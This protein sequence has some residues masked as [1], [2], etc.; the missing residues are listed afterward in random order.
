MKK[1][2]II[3]TLVLF[4]ASTQAH[5]SIVVA[6][7]K[8]VVAL[9][10]TVSS[11][12][13][14]TATTTNVVTITGSAFTGATAVSFGGTAAASFTVV[15][16]TTITAIVAA[17]ST[18]NVSVTTPD[19]I[20]S[21][22]GF[23][24]CVSN[25][26]YADADGD[27]FGNPAISYV[28]CAQAGYVLNNLD[29]NDAQ[30]RYQDLDNDGFGSTVKVPCGGRTNK[31]DCNDNLVTYRDLDGDGYGVNV[32]VPCGVT[33]NTDCNDGN[34]SVYQSNLL[35]V[36]ADGD[37]Y[38]SGA[39]VVVCYGATVPTGF[40]VSNIAIDCNDNFAAIN[41]GVLEVAYNGI[42]DDCDGQVDEGFPLITTTLLPEICNTTL[43]SIKSIIGITT[44]ISQ[45]LITGYRI[46]A[47]NG[48]QVQTIERGIGHFT[49][50]MFPSYEY[51]TTYTIDI[52]LQRNGVW[53][54]YY[55][56]AC[57]ISTPAIL[58]EGGASAVSPLQCGITLPKINTLLATTSIQ[59][60]TGYK[61]RITNLTDAVGPNP[62]QTI[63]RTLNW[64]TLQMLT[65]CNYGTTYR[66]EVAVKTTG[67]FGGYG[68]P[69]EIS[70]PPSPSL[71]NCEA[72]VPTKNTLIACASLA[73]VTQ[74]RFQVTRDSDLASTTIDRSVNYFNFSNV[75]GSILTYGALY[76]VRVAVMTA[77]TWSPY[78]DACQITSPA[79]TA[80][81][82]SVIDE[83]VMDNFRAV[84]SPNPFNADFGIN[85]IT[86]SQ[87]NVSVKVYDLLGRMVESTEVKVSDLNTTKVGAQYPAG[88]YNAVVS[89]RGIVKTLR[90]IKR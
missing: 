41:P 35:Y 26:Y 43:A 17:G 89:Q 25:T 78:G 45:N 16:D 37:G 33:N 29:C 10:P 8:T 34:T 36:D 3:L 57:Q 7:N 58:A 18:G 64:F 42:D 73:G 59:G 27:G 20:D 1:I 72:V 28:G 22:I 75:P 74:Y 54:G 60:V 15:N 70:S 39:T 68:S 13:P 30:T 11:F 85:V 51:A 88:V 56:S 50:Q 14:T 40:A 86:S 62:V 23:T 81:A 82:G 32:L 21:K 83:I 4:A 6:T 53:L 63:T 84:A 24:F 79:T 5:N 12:L 61:F 48:A 69:C 80:K 44:L 46:R 67:G 31:T 77:G 2:I 49:M 90:I 55:G 47:T 71:T 66:I 19:G 9:P 52:E 65:R 38:T 87:D 76:N